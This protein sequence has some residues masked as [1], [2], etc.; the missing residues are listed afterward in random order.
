MQ[1]TLTDSAVKEWLSSI[2]RGERQPLAAPFTQ[3]VIDQIIDISEYEGV[4][5]LL[6]EKLDENGYFDAL[7]KQFSERLKSLEFQYAAQQLSRQH[8]IKSIL[9]LFQIRKLDFLLMKGEALAS[10]IY[11]AA[12]MR[13]RCDVDLL[14]RDKYATEQAWLTLEKNGYK[15]EETLQGEFVGY[16]FSCSKLLGTGTTNTFDIHNQIND[17]LW[18]ARMF[19]FDELYSHADN[20]NYF[21]RQVKCTS[22]VY[23]LM[24]ASLHRISNKPNGNQDRL[25]WLYDI[26]LLCRSLSHS[27]WET[28]CRLAQ[29]KVLAKV[30]LE[31]IQ[32]ASHYLHTEIPSEFLIKLAGIATREPK[33]LNHMN[34]RWRL[35]LNDWLH[36]KGVA[37]KLRQ[38]REHLFP[39]PGYIMRKY[40]LTSKVLLPYFYLKRIFQGVIKYR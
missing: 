17:Y 33:G 18:F 22:P 24:H 30:C 6:R 35:Y 20:I 23:S 32:Q 2:L 34:Q 5:A 39:S 15:R 13:T 1:E 3:A 36:N 10:S 11:P 37:N 16:Q 40:Q 8:E 4:T 28:F 26:H 12:H 9:I 27:E 29:E 21:G 31:G 14:F 19:S 38:L 7:P 25:I